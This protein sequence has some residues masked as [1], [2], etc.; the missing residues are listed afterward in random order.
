[1]SIEL[2]GIRSLSDQQIAEAYGSLREE[3]SR[4]K[5]EPI[6]GEEIV[7]AVG[8]R[9]LAKLPV[10]QDIE[11]HEEYPCVYAADLKGNSAVRGFFSYKSS[12]KRPFIAILVTDHDKTTPAVELIFQR[13]NDLKNNFIVKAKTR[14]DDQTS[15]L[16]RIGS[17]VVGGEVYSR[18]KSLLEGNEI[19][20]ID[21]TIKM[22]TV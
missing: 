12:V 21:G 13:F 9:L 5:M 10:I 3:K 7:A 4:R 11:T 22:A 20:T 15:V 14:F 1:M 16:S 19:P 18:I 8:A 6:L 17:G 2:T